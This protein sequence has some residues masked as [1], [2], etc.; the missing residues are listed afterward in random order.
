MTGAATVA[1]LRLTGNRAIRRHI[2]ETDQRSEM[3]LALADV[4]AEPWAAHVWHRD[5]RFS[6]HLPKSDNTVQQ[7]AASGHPDQRRGLLDGL[8]AAVAAQGAL[9]LPEAVA[10]YVEAI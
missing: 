6:R 3:T 4:V 2:E 9:S 1:D 8:R 7:I 5:P 10:E